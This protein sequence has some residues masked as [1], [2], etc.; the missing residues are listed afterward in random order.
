[1]ENMTG[2]VL[3]QFCKSPVKKD[4][5]LNSCI[6]RGT[7]LI[8]FYKKNRCN[9]L[10]SQMAHT[11]PCSYMAHAGPCSAAWNSWPNFHPH[12]SQY[13]YT[14]RGGGGGTTATGGRADRKH[15]HDDGRSENGV[16]LRRPTST[17]HLLLGVNPHPGKN[18]RYHQ[19]HLV[20]F[21]APSPAA[22]STVHTYHQASLL[23]YLVIFSAILKNITRKIQHMYYCSDL[24]II[25]IC[26]SDS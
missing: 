22:R 18:P 15:H 26:S 9:G 5:Y 10:S 14:L 8:V 12:P 6:Y 16:R 11:G 19:I 23:C 3:S 17:Q 1:M 24:V 2:V 13:R 20:Q 4:I 7:D 25:L 21:W